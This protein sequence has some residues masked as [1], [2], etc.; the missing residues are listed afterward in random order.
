MKVHVLIYFIST[1]PYCHLPCGTLSIYNCLFNN[2]AG[3]RRMIGG[4]VRSPKRLP[5]MY[6]LRSD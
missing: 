2:I 4:C 5:A 1:L 6:L 3:G